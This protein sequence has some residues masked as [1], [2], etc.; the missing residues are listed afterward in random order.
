MTVK[1]LAA[2]AALG[3]VAHSAALSAALLPVLGALVAVE[4]AWVLRRVRRR[5][6]TPRRPRHA[7][8]A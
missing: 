8:G 1:L 5:K 3:A 4:A 2:A 7:Y 6:D